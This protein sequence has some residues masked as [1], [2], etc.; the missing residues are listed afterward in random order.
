[1]ASDS[2]KYTKLKE[3]SQNIHDSLLHE[4]TKTS[5]KSKKQITKQINDVTETLKEKH[6]KVVK[7]LDKKIK[8]K[9]SEM[10]KMKKKME[11]L[12]KLSNSINHEK[13]ME[14]IQSV[15]NQTVK[16]LKEKLLKLEQFKENAIVSYDKEFE[17]LNKKTNKT[18]KDAQKEIDESFNKSK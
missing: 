16:L 3:K 7:E 15:K 17:K 8:A 13:F 2:K 4:I 5:N 18:M 9:K 14:E 12:T 10:E 11:E 1:M 6:N